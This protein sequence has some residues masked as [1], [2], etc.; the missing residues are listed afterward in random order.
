M[1]ILTLIL[2]FIIGSIGAACDGDWSGIKA[3]GKVILFFVLFF[4]IAYILANPLLLV[5][6]II[7]IMLI[8]SAL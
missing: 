8:I 6:I 3:I 1:H 7:L 5:F 4:L 2:M